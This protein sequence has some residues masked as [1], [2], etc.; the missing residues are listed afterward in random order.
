MTMTERYKPFIVMHVILW[1]LHLLCKSCMILGKAV[2]HGLA[3]SALN[4]PGS[5]VQQKALV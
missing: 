4:Q 3:T 1:D 2:C 5:L